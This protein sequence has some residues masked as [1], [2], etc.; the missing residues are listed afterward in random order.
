MQRQIWGA[1]PFVW[2]LVCAIVAI[3]AILA[4]TTVFSDPHGGERRSFL[5]RCHDQAFD[6]GVTDN[7]LALARRQFGS[8][9]SAAQQIAFATAGIAVF[10]GTAFVLMYVVR[11]VG[12]EAGSRR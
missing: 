11:Q 12:Q 3:G 5:R 7:C 6:Q 4:A 9:N 1:H 10:A 2:A 8:F